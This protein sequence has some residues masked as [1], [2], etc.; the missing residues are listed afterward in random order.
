[1]AETNNTSQSTEGE[2]TK[3]AG[4]SSET[5]ENINR[6]EVEALKKAHDAANFKA[7]NLEKELKELRTKIGETTKETAA[8][9]G[10]INK[11][12]DEYS[13]DLKAKE[14]EVSALSNKLKDAVIKTKFFAS[15]PNLFIPKSFETVWKLLE[16]E[17]EIQEDNG[18]QKIVVKNSALDFE[19]YL[20]KYA[21]ENEFFAK[22]QGVGG[23]GTTQPNGKALAEGELSREDFHKMSRQEQQAWAVKNPAG[24]RKILSS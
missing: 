20:K 13:K 1:M 3:A 17:F 2:S 15:A 8:K 10:D 18:Q 24:I 9:D 11:L 16:N 7:R 4:E 12:R 22:A 14:D 6:E 21:A 23:A 19:S 5:K